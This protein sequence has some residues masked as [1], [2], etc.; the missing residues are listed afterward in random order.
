MNRVGGLI[1]PALKTWGIGEALRLEDIRKS[2]PKIVGGQISSHT[3]PVALKDSELVINV[4]SPVWLQQLSFLKDDLT[5]KLCAFEVKSVRFRHGRIAVSGDNSSAAESALKA[6]KILGSEAAGEIE[7]AVS[8]VKDP[9]LRD[10]IRKLME[11]ALSQ[12]S[13]QG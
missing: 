6:R 12:G 13:R 9:E 10:S 4:D 5:R 2:W 8:G 11:R 7:E 3:S 1:L